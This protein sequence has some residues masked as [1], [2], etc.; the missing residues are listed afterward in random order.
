M[1]VLSC[2]RLERPLRPACS[3]APGGAAVTDPPRHAPTALADSPAHHPG[4]HIEFRLLGPIEVGGPG[5][6]VDTAGVKQRAVLAMLLLEP[7]VLVPLDR[8]IDGLWGEQVPP[9]AVNTLQSY[10][11]RLR[12]ALSAVSWSGA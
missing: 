5:Q 6:V 4:G 3:A 12:R 1:A 2:G 11:S 9:S 7:N 10:V 8:L